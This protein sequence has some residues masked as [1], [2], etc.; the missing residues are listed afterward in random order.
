M[1]SYSVSTFSAILKTPRENLEK[2]FPAIAIFSL[3]CTNGFGQRAKV[4]R[5]VPFCITV[6]LIPIQFNVV[7]ILPLEAGVSE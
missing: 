1:A 7:T 6:I 2:K 5:I 3:Q 4:R